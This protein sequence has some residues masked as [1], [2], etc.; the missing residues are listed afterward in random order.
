MVGQAAIQSAE[1]VAALRA[2]VANES[3]LAVRCE[4][5]LAKHFLG[6]KYKL[7]TRIRPQPLLKAVVNLISPGSYCFA[8]IRTRHFDETLLSEI[9][10]G[11]E[12][13]VLLGAGYDSRPF[14]FQYRLAGI[15]VFEL[16]APGTQAHKR[17][18]LDKVV[19]AAPPNLT[20]IA[21]DF[22]KA[23]FAA[24]LEAHG[25]SPAKRTLFLWEGVSY[26]LP[27]PVVE[28]VLTFVGSCAAGSSI[29]FDYAI[30]GFVNGD[31]ST[32][33]GRQIARWLKKIG[34][35]FLFGL[36]AGDAPEFLARC[37]L[38]IVSDL[39]PEDLEKAYLRTK[40]GDCLGR[41]LGHIR[42][43]HARTIGHS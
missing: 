39:G 26:Y 6:T 37:K 17:H 5:P 21:L 12:Q 14:R 9:G 28:S 32:Y 33:G 19:K 1:T 15:N 27:P 4:D 10:A 20:F 34:E 24:A 18:I 25:F 31:H 38:R 42:M 36:D 3:A 2:A 35:P 7:L 40:S 16:D 30:K 43:V 41:T 11:V 29:L 22:T 13:V 8:I 23:S